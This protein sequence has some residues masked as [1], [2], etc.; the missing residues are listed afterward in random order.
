MIHQQERYNRKP[1]DGSKI[2]LFS[3]FAIILFWIGIYYIFA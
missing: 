3:S 1:E 2:I